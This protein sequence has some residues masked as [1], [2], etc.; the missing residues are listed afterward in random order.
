MFSNSE[1]MKNPFVSIFSRFRKPFDCRELLLIFS[2]LLVVGGT[3]SF[4]AIYLNDSAL[5]KKVV[6]SGLQNSALLNVLQVYGGA[7]SPREVLE[8]VGI[9]RADILQ[10]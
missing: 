3:M 6:A 8:Q 1:V 5:G 2:L 4:F 9:Y 10:F 7:E